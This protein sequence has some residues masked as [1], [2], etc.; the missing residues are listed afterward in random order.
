[1]RKKKEEDDKIQLSVVYFLSSHVLKAT[2]A[3]IFVN[4]LAAPF[5]LHAWFGVCSFFGHYPGNT[6]ISFAIPE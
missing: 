4:C 5:S 1:M 6:E 2:F 3:S